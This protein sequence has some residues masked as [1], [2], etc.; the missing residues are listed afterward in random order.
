MAT[1]TD[2]PKATIPNRRMGQSNGRGLQ[3]R[4][5]RRRQLALDERSP[6]SAQNTAVLK[7]P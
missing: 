4:H 1:K 3:Q 7:M 5:D 6:K 2:H